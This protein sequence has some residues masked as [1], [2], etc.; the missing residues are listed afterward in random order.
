V[1]LVLAEVDAKALRGM[2]E[3]RQWRSL[4]KLS[5]QGRAMRSWL[6]QQGL[7]EQSGP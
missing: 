5:N 4:T 7:L 6:E 3:E 2:L 1:Y